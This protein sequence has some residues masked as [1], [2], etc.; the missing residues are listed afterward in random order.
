MVCLS[1]SDY[2]ND[3]L[4]LLGCNEG[5]VRL[6]E[7]NNLLEGRVEVCK[8]GIWGTVCHRSWGNVD[9]RV[10]C[11]QLGL[12]SAGIAVYALSKNSCHNSK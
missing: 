2:D 4:L 5:N 12:S 11:R 6:V 1:K 7:G 10:V 8:Y 3:K 9:A